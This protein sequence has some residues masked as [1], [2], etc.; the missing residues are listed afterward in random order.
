MRALEAA[1]KRLLGRYGL[2]L[3]ATWRLG[4]RDAALHLKEV[5]GRYGVDCVLDVGANEGQFRD[6][7]RR[8]VEYYG[9]IVSFEP[10][11]RPLATLQ[12]RAL[13]DKKWRIIG[14]AL[15]ASK[16]TAT[17]NVAAHSTLSSLLLPRFDQTRHS[18]AN[19]QTVE[20]LQ[21]AVGTLDE[22]LP[23]IMSELGVGRP[24]LKLDTQGFDLEVIKGSAQTIRSLVGLQVELS[25]IPLYEGMP[26][27][28]ETIAALNALGF[29]LSNLFFV[30]GE[31]DLR[32]VEFDC[33]MVQPQKFN[34]DR[35][36]V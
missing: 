6:F 18:F 16:G 35:R 28:V 14:R 36:S 12:Q 24:F 27:Y 31:R 17:L 30:A 5:F 1:A 21:V 11:P 9:W 23:I 19:R 20:T 25:V 32:L 13:V 3:T 22:E 29:H 10:A 2:T 4:R 7:L 34:L 33:V 15:G 8:E 26:N